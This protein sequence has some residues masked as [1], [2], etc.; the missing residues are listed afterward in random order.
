MGDISKMK[1]TAKKNYSDLKHFQRNPETLTTD[2]VSYW[3]EGSMMTA[4]MSLEEAKNL[5]IDQKA[6]VISDG[7]IGYLNPEEYDLE[8]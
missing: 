2:K 1:K 3:N 8:N 5:V 6:F 4:M 7:N